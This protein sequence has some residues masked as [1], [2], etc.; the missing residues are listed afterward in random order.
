MYKILTLNNIS[1]AGLD[2]LP[3]EI[4][5]I[6]NTIDRLQSIIAAPD[7]YTQDQAALQEKL[8]AEMRARIKED[9]DSVPERDEDY[10]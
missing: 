1:V 10:F 4:H 2:R 9:D 6:E 5:E 7:F 8:V 3:T